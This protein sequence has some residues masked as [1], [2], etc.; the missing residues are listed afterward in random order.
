MNCNCVV[1][2]RY[3]QN[4]KCI[5]TVLPYPINLNQFG[6][7][8]WLMYLLWSRSEIFFSAFVLQISLICLTLQICCLHFVLAPFAPCNGLLDFLFTSVT[9]NIVASCTSLYKR[10]YTYVS[11]LLKYHLL[12]PL[13]RCW[14]LI[15]YRICK[16]GENAPVEL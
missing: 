4:N 16:T 3:S 6:D 2:P 9:G 13:L 11:L 12:N 14:F 1:W 8:L 15:F 5:E 7:L 10:P